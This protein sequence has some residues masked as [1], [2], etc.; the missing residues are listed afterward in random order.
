MAFWNDQNGWFGGQPAGQSV[1]PSTYSQAPMF[2]APAVM[3]ST[4]GTSSPT[5]GGGGG[6]MAPSAGGM[7]G[8]LPAV[9]P[10]AAQLQK[11]NNALMIRMV[12]GSSGGGIGLPKPPTTYGV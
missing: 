7:T 3:P 6:M 11:R 10:Q 8:Q 9:N 2:S 12:G 1:G 4:Y 5:I